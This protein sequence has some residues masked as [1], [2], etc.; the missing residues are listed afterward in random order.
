MNWK[1]CWLWFV[2][3]LRVFMV[4]FLYC[5]CFGECIW[6]LVFAWL[7]VGSG[8]CLGLSPLVIFGYFVLGWCGCSGLV[9]IFHDICLVSVTDS[10]QKTKIF[11]IWEI[12]HN[13]TSENVLFASDCWRAYVY[14]WKGTDGIWSA[15][16]IQGWENNFDQLAKNLTKFSK[17][18]WSCVT[19][20]YTLL[21][22]G[23]C[24][25]ISLWWWYMR[26]CLFV[27][28][29]ECAVTFLWIFHLK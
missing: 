18:H 17:F 4:L 25:K 26:S 6:K 9:E 22:P 5:G 23:L 13:G 10:G 7:L 3:N 11:E 29:C 1:S 24:R 2:N 12:I 8:M 21:G 16:N 19:P 14:R 27:C 28:V 20:D 15:K